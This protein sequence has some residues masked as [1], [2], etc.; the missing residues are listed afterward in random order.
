MIQDNKQKMSPQKRTT[1]AICSLLAPLLLLPGLLHAE[2]EQRWYQV[3]V[4][5]FSQNNPDYHDSELWPL[6]Y[7]LPDMEQSRELVKNQKSTSSLY[8]E[9]FSLVGNERL[10][11]TETARRIKKASDVEL[12]LHLGWLQPG[13]PEEKA[14]AVHI[15]DGMLERGAGEMRPLTSGDELPK[16]DGTL[17]LILSRYLHLESDLIWREPLPP[18]MSLLPAAAQSLQG[19]DE[20]A[21]ADEEPA[22]L[23][24]MDEAAAEAQQ[25]PA[26]ITHQV[27]RLKQSRR[28]R[29]DEIHY[30][31]HPLFGI[32]ALVSRYEPQTEAAAGGTQP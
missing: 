31:D 20:G 11:L 5:L 4:I 23:T 15:Y 28:M 7:T 21:A 32:I 3:E 29:S 13:L 22:S 19:D 9:P 10:R 27:F 14:V 8:P 24:T 17:R 30:L 12:V 16:L 25:M 6:D 18:G 2:E 1:R 26:T